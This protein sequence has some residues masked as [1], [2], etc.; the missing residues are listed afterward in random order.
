MSVRMY[1]LVYRHVLVICLEE[2][3]AHSAISEH[4]QTVWN[5]TAYR[6]ANG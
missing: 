6:I 3:V 4:Q 5:E 1:I 2:R